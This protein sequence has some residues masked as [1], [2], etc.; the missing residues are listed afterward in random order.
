MTNKRG[1]THLAQTRLALG[2]VQFGLSYGITNSA[3]QVPEDEVSRLL[4][5]AANAG[6]TTLDTASLY[7]SSEAVLGRTMR[8]K[9]G[10]IAPFRVITKTSKVAPNDSA[11]DAVARLETSFTTS[12]AHLGVSHVAG[13]MVHE[14]DDLLGPHGDALWAA[15]ARLKTQ[16]KA[17]KIGASIYSGAQ[18]D[19]LLARYPL[20]LVQIPTNALDHRLREGGQLTRLKAAGV[21]V[22]ARSIFLQ[23]LLLQKPEAIA[24]KFGALRDAIAALHHAFASAS[25]SPLSG[26]IAAVLGHN[27]IDRLV[28]GVTRISELEEI[29]AAEQ[30]ASEVLARNP[31]VLNALSGIRIDDE[32][33]LSP[34]RWGELQ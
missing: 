11:A 9:S 19:A 15:M 10:K 3:G 8:L 1:N 7:G 18:I 25:L 14:S 2:T 33:I 5:C 32:R 24:P 6:I 27:D 12:L 34:A 31:D 16:G 17:Q 4:T 28:M 29:I 30:Q 23:G 13:L 20:D 26:L 22:H 21:E